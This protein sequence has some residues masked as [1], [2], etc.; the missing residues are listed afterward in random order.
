MG[1]RLRCHRPLAVDVQQGV[2]NRLKV[3]K[4][5]RD[6]VASARKALEDIHGLA[7]D[8]KPSEVVRLLRPY[9]ARVLAV[10]LSEVGLDSPSG[11]QIELF[12]REWR[13]VRTDTD[14]NDLLAMGLEAGPEIGYLLDR[15]L[16]AR[17]DG[18]VGDSHG[19]QALLL[20]LL[21][22]RATGAHALPPIQ[23]PAQDV[24]HDDA[25]E[26]ASEV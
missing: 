19:E 1:G 6:D 23:A 11:R 7:P 13:E 24:G 20:S 15:L 21:Q 16:A 4:S 25:S 18:E 2:M 14:G 26:P 12:L 3:R 5:T 17:L 8:V 9:P 10:A 22:E